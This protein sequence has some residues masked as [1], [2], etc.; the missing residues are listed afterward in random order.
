[1]E[2]GLQLNIP[3]MDARHEEF[4]V[5]LEQL[6][7][8]SAET[9]LP[10]FAEMVAHTEAHFAAEEATMEVHAYC[11]LQEHRDEHANLLGEMKYFYEKA[12]KRPAFGKSYV[13]EYAFDKFRRHVINI[14]AQ[15]AMFL[16]SK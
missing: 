16:K 15:L 11:G 4:F 10:L 14:D 12:Q 8:S 3:E 1:M 7:S 6:K 5:L 13:H 9:F 2:E